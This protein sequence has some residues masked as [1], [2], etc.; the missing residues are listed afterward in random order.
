MRV[1]AKRKGYFSNTRIDKGTEFVILPY[2]AVDPKTGQ[3]VVVTEEQQ[4]SWKWMEKVTAADAKPG[5]PA[6]KVEAPKAA[7]QDHLRRP[8]GEK[9][10]I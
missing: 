3:E 4:F 7:P 1:R 8:T 10:V 9:E 5:M 6:A 2:K